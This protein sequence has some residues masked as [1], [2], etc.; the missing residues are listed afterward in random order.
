MVRFL[1]FYNKVFVDCILNIVKYIFVRNERHQKIVINIQRHVYHRHIY[2]LVKSYLINGYNVVIVPNISSIKQFRH[3]R[4][5]RN[6]FRNKRLTFGFIA[7]CNVLFTDILSAPKLIK[8]KKRCYISS[9]YFVDEKTNN[10]F[11]VQ[12]L[13]HPDLY[14]QRI[15]DTPHVDFAERINACLAYGN[16]NSDIYLRISRFNLFNVSNRIELLN[17]IIELNRFIDSELIQDT[18]YEIQDRYENK[19]VIAK[20]DKNP[21]PITKIRVELNKFRYTFCFPGAEYPISHNLIEALS[22]GCVPIIEREYAALLS[23]PLVDR[24]D[25]FIFDDISS[26]DDTLRT[27]FSIAENEWKNMSDHCLEYYENY[28]TPFSIVKQI[29]LLNNDDTIFLLGCIS[30]N[31]EYLKENV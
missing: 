8:Y 28:C 2:L 27:A 17:K 5:L 12:I 7:N 10:G 22:V 25:A 18:G 31:Y 30:D 1:R 15:W 13:Q 23:P 20:V 6:E 9:L 19:V 29:N 21:I 16:F 24:R 26:L 14:I 11:K 4:Y 3:C